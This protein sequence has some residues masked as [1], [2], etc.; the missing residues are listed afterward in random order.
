MCG[1]DERGAPLCRE[2]IY[3]NGKAPMYVKV[4]ITV[5]NGGASFHIREEGTVTENFVGYLPDCATATTA[6]LTQANSTNF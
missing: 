5:R 4:D 1:G 6:S 2:F 3:D